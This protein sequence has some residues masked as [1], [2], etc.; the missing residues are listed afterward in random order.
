MGWYS[1]LLPLILAIVVLAFASCS[2]ESTQ[3]DNGN[4]AGDLP[5][6]AGS[7]TNGLPGIPIDAGPRTESALPGD[8][9]ATVLGKDYLTE[10]NGTVDG[11]A[12]FLDAPAGDG[13]GHAAY[14]LYKLSGLSG[15]S[16]HSLMV[17]CAPGLEDQYF[18]GVADY[19]EG[20]WV[21]FGPTEL[22]EF[23]ID[24]TG[25]NHRF[26]AQLGNFYF[27]VVCHNGNSAT[28]F[29]STLFYGDDTGHAPGM[30]TELVA[31]DGTHNDGVALHW[32]AGAG[33]AYYEIFRR[34]DGQ[35]GEFVKIGASEVTEF[36]DGTA[37]PGVVYLYKVRSVNEHGSSSFSNV[38]S[39]FAAEGGGDDW[40][41][42]GLH[43]TDGVYAEKV[44]LEWLPGAGDGF[45]FNIYRRVDGSEGAFDKIG[46]SATNS[47]NDLT[48]VPGV[49]YIY[50]VE[51]KAEG[52]ESCFTNM[53]SGYAAGQ[54]GSGD[55]NFDVVATD[56]SFSDKVVIEWGSGGD[57]VWYDVLRK[58][59][60]FEEDFTIISD[61][62]QTRRFEDLTAEPGV[63][64]LYK[65]RAYFGGQYCDSA[66]DS[67]YRAGEGG[68]GSDWCPSGLVAT[69]G[70]YSDKVRIEWMPG[71]GDAY[72]FHVW[73]RPSGSEI[74]TSIGETM[75]SDFNDT[76]AEA[77]VTYFYKV[78]KSA[79][80]HEDCASNWDTGYRAAGG[81][82]DDWCPR[83]IAA[84][85]GTYLDHVRVEWTPGSGDG[86]F[87]LYRR[88][89]GHENWI[90]VH[91]TV[92]ADFNDFEVTPGITYFYK[93]IK[94]APQHDECGAGPD[95][96]FAAVD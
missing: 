49:V 39:G 52:R 43:A 59:D 33:A 90:L 36:F 28:H 91:E 11:D 61:E 78:V 26:I 53:D 93:V 73:R 6:V 47:Y 10:Q 70:T 50:K 54:G 60:G 95:S 4:P 17:E 41:P 35:E 92:G 30:P 72:W 87:H 58:R 69:D 21:W 25:E 64:Y 20:R 68:G 3:L 65:I 74:W 8:G 67:G 18:V 82:G 19:T 22:P 44:R 34:T 2:G 51:K 77:Q 84:S 76:T 89:D 96:G 13:E 32:N 86:T 9:S 5:V 88:Q 83:E 79:E 29:Q 55:C 45:W 23:E 81:G 85:D 48:A 46:E 27:I 56:G 80:G 31:S 38:D 15:K 12:L 66:A 1:R 37:A 63:V 94:S 40:C 71:G 16:A 62:T 7:D 42:S 24:L 75:G 57:G 14:G